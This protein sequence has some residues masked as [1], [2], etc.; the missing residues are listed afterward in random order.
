MARKIDTE[1]E[2]KKGKKKIIII[3]MVIVLLGVGGFC[4]WKYVV[5]KPQSK[6]QVVTVL[7]KSLD[8]YGYSLT[9]K[10][11]KYFKAE[12]EELKELL[13]KDKIDEKEYA[14][15]VARM[16]VI[17]FYTLST[18]LNKYDVG[19]TEFF[20]DKKR[21]MFET[22]AMDT[23]YASLLDNTYGDRKQELPEVTNVETVS[24]EETTY[25]LGGDKVDGYLIKLKISYE[26]D[27]KYDDE[28][29]VVVCKEEGMRWSV[30]DFQPTLKPEYKTKKDK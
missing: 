28:A 16:F 29:S 26:K 7:D 3:M 20:Y 4:L 19:G 6:A 21:E 11:S 23:V 9:D 27:M 30:V 2:K 5:K 13:Q 18:K 15:K 14:T 1:K 12:Y 22:K 10:D 25:T 17:D 8:E 24:T